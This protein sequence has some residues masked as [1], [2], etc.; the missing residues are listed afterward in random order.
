MDTISSMIGAGVVINFDI[1][2]A[3]KACV[4]VLD[5]CFTLHDNVNKKSHYT[6]HYTSEKESPALLALKKHTELNE[7]V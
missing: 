6:G 5:M 3:S 4:S 2:F 1:I 7:L